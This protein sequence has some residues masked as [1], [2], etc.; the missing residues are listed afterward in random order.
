MCN[1]N[2]LIRYKKTNEI[3]K[4]AGFLMAVTSNSYAYNSDGDGV[5]FNSG[6]LVK[7]K[8]KI[9]ILDY[10]EQISD[11]SVIIAHQRLATSGLTTKYTQPF[12][13]NDFVMA[14]NGIINDFL[15][16]EGSDTWGFFNRFIE[17]FEKSDIKDRTERITKSIKELLDKLENGSYSI[18]IYD[19]A[20]NEL[21]Y[22]KN[23]LT[24]ISF[25]SNSD[26]MY[27]TTSQSNS[28]YLTL[29]NNK[30]REL[31]VKNHC[32]YKLTLNN[33]QKIKK[34]GKI[35]HEEQKK[36]TVNTAFYENNRYKDFWQDKEEDETILTYSGGQCVR[37][38][39]QTNS[40]SVEDNKYLCNSCSINHVYFWG[41][42]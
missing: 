7:Q 39:S 5:Y 38:G 40:V 21:Y 37:C 12:E 8:D 17:T 23:A 35:H 19:K 16:G 25:Y 14:H 11:S 26:Y 4:I 36:I 32:I 15:A 33:E 41:G 13:N 18:I 30:F 6:L 28:T 24:N 2:V 3:R 10:I 31:K 42:Y 29:F 1:L 22:F 34:V 20:T 9:N 27:I